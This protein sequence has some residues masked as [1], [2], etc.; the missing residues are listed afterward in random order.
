[1]ADVDTWLTANKDMPRQEVGPTLF[2]KQ[3]ASGT[4]VAQNDVIRICKIPRY[5]IVKGAV[6]AQSGT[7]GASAT[8]QLRRET[9]ALTAAT[10][11]GAAT[12]LNQNAVDEPNV[13]DGDDYLNIV[14]A[15]AAA[16]TS[17]TVTVECWFD[18]AVNG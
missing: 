6:L 18:W 11:A 8:A 14:V 4:A 15:G 1:M 7:L 9:T 13:D 17:A 10:T 16:G 3:F 2:R 12:F 5:A